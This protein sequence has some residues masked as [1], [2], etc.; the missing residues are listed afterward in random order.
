MNPSKR[1]AARANELRDEIVNARLS[2][3]ELVK[4][5][6]IGAGA[7]AVG[8]GLS[9][10]QALAAT[11]ASPQTRPFIQEMPLPRAIRARGNYA[12][13]S[14]A[15]QW[16]DNPHYNKPDLYDINVKEVQHEFHPDLPT[17]PIWGYNGQMGSGL[18]DA[19]YGQPVMIRFNNKLPPMH[20]HFGFG[21][22]EIT[23]HLHNFHT[24]T[25]SDGGP[26]NW[27]A[28]GGSRENYYC[29][30]RAGFDTGEEVP[31]QWRDEYGGDKRESMTTLFFHDH[32]PEFTAANC[33]KGLMA[34]FRVFD[35]D[36]TGNERTGWRLP[37]GQFDVPLII[38]DKQFDAQSGQMTFDQ[39]Q[40]DGF[41][42]D[43]HTVNG[44]IQPYFE[45]EARKYRFRL[46]NCGPSRGYRHELRHDGNRV[47]FTQITSESGNLLQAPLRNVA[48]V[49]IW[50]AER[51]DIIVDFST[52]QPGEK[53][54]LGN[55]AEMRVD[56]RG[57]G[58]SRLNP[59]DPAN[60]L[61]EFRVIPMRARRDRSR[62]PR[63]FRPMPDI[64]IPDNIKRR[65]FKFERK[66]GM[67]AINGRF[68]DPDLD[69]SPEFMANPPVQIKRNTAEI[70]EL[71]SSSH[72]WDHP[73]HIHFEEGMVLK[74]NG[75]SVSDAQRVR[76]DVYKMNGNKKEIYMRFRDFGL[77]GFEGRYVMHCHN[78]VHEDHAMMATWNIVP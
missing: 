49:E 48:G 63:S 26:W 45:V 58:S 30:M 77:P 64:I 59:D 57:I 35:E 74:N 27:Y 52:F 47:P 67:W 65:V 14:Y 17:S 43:K 28:R 51:V 20:R 9:L 34:M 75:V 25:E 18:I 56:G 19:T 16:C 23:T 11:V 73:V 32:R 61:V 5:G 31:G 50:P 76:K 62:I 42:G 6:L 53:I 10:R 12:Y 54:Y 4:L 2:R 69:H 1:A 38:A 46:L 71:D 39:F 70:W 21:Q 33:Y 8:G 36:D 37:S 15:H 55:V 3:R 68:W 22:P 66:N 60:Q 7:Y 41:I 24:A 40:T 13:D 78:M 44:K 29:M 72:G